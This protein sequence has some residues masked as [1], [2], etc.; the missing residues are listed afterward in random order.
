MLFNKKLIGLT[1]QLVTDEPVNQADINKFNTALGKYRSPEQIKYTPIVESDTSY[2]ESCD[3]RRVSFRSYG[4][5]FFYTSDNILRY[6]FEPIF[7][8]NFQFFGAASLFSYLSSHRTV[9]QP[10]S[11]YITGFGYLFCKISY[12]A[13]FI[14]VIWI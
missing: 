12:S 4:V 8:L 9:S 2:I 3:S 11:F 13:P 10:W 14:R 7:S 5:N 1:C 6:I